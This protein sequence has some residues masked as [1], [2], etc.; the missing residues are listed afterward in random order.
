MPKTIL[1]VGPHPDDIE[2]T[3]GGILLKEVA[4][5]SSVELYVMSRGESST[6]GT[7]RQRQQEA[8]AAAKL[9]GA[10]LAWATLAGKRLSLVEERER[11]KQV[12]VKQV[13]DL[14]RKMMTPK[15]CALAALGPAGKDI[16][17]RMKRAVVTGLGP[18]KI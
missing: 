11:L 3:I 1:A 10:K 4:R 13:V 8:A 15:N 5:G 7:P 9:I 12:T 6:N 16:E 17:K 14:C 18:K 2:F